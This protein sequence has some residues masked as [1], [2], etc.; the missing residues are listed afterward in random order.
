MFLNAYLFTGLI[1]TF[2]NKSLPWIMRHYESGLRWALKGWR[3]VWLLLSTFLLLIFSFVFHWHPKSAG[4]I[5]PER[6][7]EFHLCISQTA[8]W[9]Q[10]KLYR[11]GYLSTGKTRK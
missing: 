4:C 1:H 2:Q 3:P 6:R 8:S 9:N 7:S 11:F 5:F 10:C